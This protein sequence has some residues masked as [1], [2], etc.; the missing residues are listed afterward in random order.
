MDE[1]CGLD[2]VQALRFRLVTRA[3]KT[4][5]KLSKRV[6]LARYVDHIY[7]RD[8]IYTY[9]PRVFAGCFDGKVGLGR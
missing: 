6:S 9:R 8:W 5:T 7:T 2:H 1:L 4:S 3:K